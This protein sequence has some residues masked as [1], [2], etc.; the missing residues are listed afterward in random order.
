MDFGTEWLVLSFEPGADLPP[1]MRR[2]AEEHAWPV[3]SKAAYPLVERRERDGVP[4]PLVERD[5]EIAAACAASLASFFIQRGSL[6]EADT[7]EADTVEADTVEPVCESYFDEHDREVRFTLP[8]GAFPMFDIEADPARPPAP[9]APA[10]AGQ[11]GP[12]RPVPLAAAAASTRSA[13]F[14]STEEE[15]SARRDRGSRPHDLDGPRP[16]KLTRFAGRASARIGADFTKDF[17]DASRDVIQIAVPWSALPLPGRGGHRGSSGYLE[18]KGARSLSRRGAL[19][20]G[21]PSGPPGS[22]SGK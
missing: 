14:P 8:Y 13:T 2:E 16:Q 9:G 21:P 1:S 17:V 10:R 3:A 20:A 11:G 5:L 18:R 19:V 22:L 15:R 7:V 6:F 4:R 12:Q